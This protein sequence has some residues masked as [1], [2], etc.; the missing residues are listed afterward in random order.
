MYDHLS[1]AE[2]LKLCVWRE[3]RG[4]D[5]AGQA[6]VAWSVLNRAAHP[7]WW[8]HDIRSVVLKPFQYSSF[9]PNDPNVAKFPDPGDPVYRRLSVICDDCMSGALP[10]PTGGATSYF[11][12]SLD[13]KPPQWAASMDRCAVIGRIRFYRE[14]A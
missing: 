6:G 13:A 2:L 7:R 11:D 5:P 10:D 1:D 8:G 4:E 12:A 9:N 3:A 14:R